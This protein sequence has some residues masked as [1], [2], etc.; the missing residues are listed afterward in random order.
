M[1]KNKVIRGIMFLVIFL[2]VFSYRLWRVGRPLDLGEI[3]YC[4]ILFV[5]P[6]YVFLMSYIVGRITFHFLVRDVSRKGICIIFIV[7]SLV[8]G[9]YAAS[10]LFFIG[11]NGT[12]GWLESHFL[13]TYYSRMLMFC[14]ST[15][16]AILCVFTAVFMALAVTGKEILNKIS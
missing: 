4:Y 16:C 3:D 2:A 5:C 1:R 8:W 12:G 10:L 9:I 13:Q 14:S 11:L 15:R 6:M 7:E